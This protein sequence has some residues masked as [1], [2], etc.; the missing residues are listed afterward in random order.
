[1]KEY[2][3]K[4]IIKRI[5]RKYILKYFIFKK[6]K[7]CQGFLGLNLGAGNNPI[8]GWINADIDSKYWSVMYLNATKKFPFRKNTFDYIISEHLLEHLSIEDAKKMLKECFRILKKGGKIRISTPDIKFI[9]SLYNK[10]KNNS[11]YIKKITNR[12]LKDIYG[13]DYRPLFIIN[14][15]FYNWEHKFLYDEEFLREILKKTGF[16]DVKRELYGESR[17]KNLNMVEAHEKGVGDIR[18]CKIESLILEAT[19][20]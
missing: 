20:K 10:N 8:N 9:I 7:D 2:Y 11:Y 15:A 17:D 16:N 18:V 3:F 4:I 12:F 14:N 13:T 19:K 1:M 5:V 6:I